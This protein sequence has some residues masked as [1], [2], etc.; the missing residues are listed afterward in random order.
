[1]WLII[2]KEKSGNRL[3]PTDDSDVGVT[4]FKSLPALLRRKKKEMSE[5]TFNREMKSI[6]YN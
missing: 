4:E 6:K 1:M 5:E 2:K 3:W